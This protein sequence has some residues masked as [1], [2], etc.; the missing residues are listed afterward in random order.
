LLSRSR[1]SPK[2]THYA[3]GAVL[4]T[5]L[6]LGA[7]VAADALLDPAHV[8][9]GYLMALGVLLLV[10]IWRLLFGTW[11]PA[12]KATVLGTFLFWIILR[13]L[14]GETPPEQLAHGIAIA[15]AIVPAVVWCA[16]FLP[17]HRERLSV[18][19]SLFFAGMLS[20]VPILFYDALV[21]RGVDLDFFLFRIDLQSFSRSS[22][23]FVADTWPS[24]ST[25]GQSIVS[26]FVAFLCVG[27]IE[28]GSKMWVLRR[29]G[30]QFITSIDDMM[31]LAIVVAI[32]FAF[33]ENITSTG[34][35][36]SFVREYLLDP[37]TR[38]WV[39]FAGNVAG[40]SVLTS[41]VHIVSTGV[42]GYFLGLA[43]FA[44]PLLQEA[45]AKG[46]RQRI[47][48]YVHGLFGMRRTEL[49][50]REMAIVGFV[51]AA[52]LHAMS[53]FLVSLPDAL[54][55]NPRTVGDLF[56][57]PDGSPLHLIALLLLPTLLYVVGG[58]FLLTTLFQRKENMRERGVIEGE[59]A[60]E[61]VMGE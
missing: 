6:S 24:L 40:R 26:M 20:T 21:R 29:T 11:D 31:Q 45:A 53:N 23:A 5:T 50:A 38:D 1:K 3:F 39:A 35:F 44:G 8:F 18:V 60:A 57:S 4:G 2:I 55:G 7:M 36:V 51:L 61:A 58:F 54:P 49:F 12:T 28:E 19:F 46:R 47:L 25:V 52:L 10:V 42:I 17:Y 9:S 27:C 48:H 15:V 13:I 33:A 30:K 32:G 56:G 37:T 41:M 34:Y 59:A 22:Q 16:I 43:Y 14:L